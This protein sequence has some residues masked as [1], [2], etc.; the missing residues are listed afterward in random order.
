VG[1]LPD[2]IPEIA[3]AIGH[4][5]MSVHVYSHPRLGCSASL[6]WGVWK[7]SESVRR[8][9]QIQY[10]RDTSMANWEDALSVLEQC[11]MAAR[12]QLEMLDA[13]DE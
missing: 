3:R 1:A 4:K 12:R 2:G 9:P 11:I 6:S 8:V 13:L 5:S 10:S 7:G